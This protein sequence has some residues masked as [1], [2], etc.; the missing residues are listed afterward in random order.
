MLRPARDHDLVIDNTGH[1]EDGVDQDTEPVFSVSRNHKATWYCA[2]QDWYVCFYVWPFKP[3][4]WDR[5]FELKGLPTGD[6]RLFVLDVRQGVKT[7]ARQIHKGS[8]GGAP[9]KFIYS[10][11]PPN[12]AHLRLRAVGPQFEI[13]ETGPEVLGED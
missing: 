12:T 9:H 4:T 6:V 1:V 7:Q 2:F 8:V 10:L 3:N 13:K 5:T 11:V